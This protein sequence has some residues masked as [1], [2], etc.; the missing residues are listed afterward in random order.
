VHV[1]IVEKEKQ[2]A[3]KVRMAKHLR[4]R[5]KLRPRQYPANAKEKEAL[6]TTLLEDMAKALDV[7]VSLLVSDPDAWSLNLGSCG[8]T[9]VWFF[10]IR[11]LS[12]VMFITVFI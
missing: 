9:C 8:W 10:C 12:N 7:P 2:K 6:A 4:L 5:Y 11:C 3:A 1:Q